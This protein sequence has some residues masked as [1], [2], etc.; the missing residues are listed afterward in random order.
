LT[1]AGAPYGRETGERE[2]GDGERRENANLLLG[3]KHRDIGVLSGR[4]GD[5]GDT[6]EAD[7]VDDTRRPVSRVVN[8]NLVGDRAESLR[9]VIGILDLPVSRY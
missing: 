2:F 1:E 9:F 8:V 4:E 7:L 5:G 3:N 6:L